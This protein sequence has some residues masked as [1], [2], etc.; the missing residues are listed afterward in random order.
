MTRNSLWMR[1]TIFL[2]ITSFTAE[3]V[4]F[5]KCVHLPV[6][7]ILEALS[8]KTIITFALFSNG[9]NYFYFLKKIFRKFT[10]EKGKIPIC[11]VKRECLVVPDSTGSVIFT[12][13]SPMPPPRHVLGVWI[14]WHSLSDTPPGPPGLAPGGCSY[15]PRPD[16]WHVARGRAGCCGWENLIFYSAP[17]A[18]ALT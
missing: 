2:I 1:A 13:T 11:D 8:S 18:S 14:S 12:A 6:Y 7:K 9:Y 5:G 17:S 15:H 4:V 16:A 3:A 10:L